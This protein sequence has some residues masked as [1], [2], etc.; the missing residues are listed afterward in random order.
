LPGVGGAGGREGLWGQHCS[1]VEID[2]RAV[3]MERRGSLTSLQ[4]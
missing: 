2:E 3:V 4:T 1:K